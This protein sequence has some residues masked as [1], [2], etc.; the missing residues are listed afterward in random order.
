MVKKTCKTTRDMSVLPDC[1]ICRYF[2][3]RPQGPDIPWW[4]GSA[5]Q[6][7]ANVSV[8]QPS[9]R[10]LDRR[11]VPRTSSFFDLP[12]RGYEEVRVNETKGSR[13]DV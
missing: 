6:L 8:V 13:S 3:R 5:V 4:L 1:S 7:L 12:E 2:R 11:R 10:G 9:E